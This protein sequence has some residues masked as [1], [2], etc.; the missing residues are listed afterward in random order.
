MILDE[1]VR[2]YKAFME[3]FAATIESTQTNFYLDTSLLIWLIRLGAEARAETISW[4]RSR[5]P[6]TV[7]VPVWAAHELHRHVIDGT[8]R[9]NLQHTVAETLSKYDDFVRMAAERADDPVCSARGFVDRS[10]F[11]RDLERSSVKMKQLARVVELDDLSLQRATTEVIDF[12]NEHMLGTDLTAIIQKLNFTGKFRTSH[13]VPP[14]FQDRKEENAY[15]DLVIWEEIIGDLISSASEA[16]GTGRDVVFVS[17]DKKTDWVSAAPFVINLRGET[18]KNNRDIEMDVTRAHPFLV[19][20]LVGIA[21]GKRLYVTHPGFLA[22]AVDFAYRRTGQ[23]SQVSHWLAASHR[24]DF[25]SKLAAS[26]LAKSGTQKDAGVAE[27]PDGAS[28]SSSQ[29]A[30]PVISLNAV[31]LKDLES[32]THAESA[33]YVKALAVEQESLIEG[34]ISGVCTGSMSPFKL[35]RILAEVILAE[36]T[37][38]DEKVPALFETLFNLTDTDR[39]NAAALAMISA[40]YFDR[41]SELLRS[42]HLILGAVVLSLEL[43]DRLSAAFEALGRF[44]S[45][46]NAELPYLPGTGRPQVRFTLDSADGPSGGR[47]SIRDIRVA[48]QSVLSEP[49]EELDPRSLSQLLGTRKDGCSG[50]D[51]RLLISRL[52]QIPPDRL[53]DT[54]DKNKFTWQPDAGLVR[55]DMTSPGGLSASVEESE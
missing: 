14:G 45:A 29:P 21:K 22:S 50:Q 24:P 31:S 5:P 47:R 38:L 28:V 10:A 40:A 17:R 16:Q 2:D 32:P 4:F 19:H 41:Y 15:G 37:G 23:L 25:L 54:Y 20:E 55:L 7:R 44:L 49:V 51:M 34:W 42:P 3:E 6:S 35:G 11:V 13:L 18:T 48:E 33:V 36:K 30:Q 53:T 43:D 27:A 12:A 52:F 1:Y 39:V 8:A 26:A 46:A 9:K